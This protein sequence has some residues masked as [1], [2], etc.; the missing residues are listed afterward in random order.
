M[1]TSDLFRSAIGGLWR[2]KARTILTLLGVA[3]GGCALAFSLSL[4]IGLRQMIDTEFKS[5]PTFWQ[6]HVRVA[7]QG[8]AIPE[9]EIPP[10]KIAVPGEMSD[11][12]RLRLRKKKVEEYQNSHPR[13]PPTPLTHAKLAQLRELPDVAEVQAG[14]ASPGVVW[15][16]DESRDGLV[17][18]SLP[19]TALLEEHLVAG[20]LPASPAAK[21]LL[22]AESVLYELGVQDEAAVTALLGQPL[23][24][25][26]GGVNN[27]KHLNMARLLS[28]NVRDVKPAQERL[29]EK[30]TDQ[31][32]TAVDKFD[33]TLGEK[34]A[35]K[36]LF[37]E[38]DRKKKEDETKLK[39]PWESDV[40][41][42]AEY[43]IAGVLRAPE[44]HSGRGFRDPEEWVFERGQVFLPVETGN[45]LFEQLPWVKEIGFDGV[46][47]IVR[48]G[49]DMKAVTEAVEGLGFEQH[50]ALE[51]HESVKRE[52]TMIAAGAN[53]FALVSLFIAALGITNTLVT[54]V[55]ERTREIGIFKALGATDR[56]VMVLFL[57]EGTMIGLLGGALGI[58][59]AWA[60]SFP[61]DNL[62]RKLVQQQSRDPLVTESIF[63]FPGWLVASTV[64]FAAVVT[65]LAALYPS[66][67][68]ARIQPVEA[69][70][71]E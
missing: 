8:S 52:V 42:T 64:A 33:L 11:A 53:V 36:A 13:R 43:R 59:L 5:R 48:P 44:P 69:L 60:V 41:V 38:R 65:T 17:V 67:R 58:V 3:V 66:R 15:L 1:R 7:D 22:V 4:G 39:R 54:S 9:S 12:R 40:S 23:R 14:H 2:Q 68:A 47:V 19:R 26:V 18:G 32:P 61:A 29:L 57:A 25:S 46:T 20:R 35:L 62:V 70:R 37:A 45:A 49:G 50:S 16:G 31:L 63:E 55:V 27:A 10:D 24:I 6:V 56:Q 21:E 28:L 51:W 30:V 34:T 71:H